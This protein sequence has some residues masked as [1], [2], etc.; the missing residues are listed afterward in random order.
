MQIFASYEKYAQYLKYLTL[1]L[2]AYILSGLS[3]KF[4]WANIVQFAVTPVLHFSKDQI[5]LVCA[6]LG[7]TISPYLFFWQTSQEVE[8]WHLGKK[9]FQKLPEV[10][11]TRE[12]KKMRVDVWSGMFISNLVMFFIIATTAS[13]LYAN[14]V[15]NIETASQA[16][17]ALAPFAGNNAYLLFTIGIIGTGFIAIPILAGS[18][19]YALSES[20]GWKFGLY[21]KLKRASAFYGAIIISMFI[22]L[23]MNFIGIDPIKALI[24]SAV[25]NGLIAPII[26]VQIVLMSSNKKIM[27]SVINHPLNTFLGWV[28]VFIMIGAGLLTL[29][30][31]I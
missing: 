13:T 3:L 4:D 5:V 22:G 8:E 26:L 6:V 15:V 19:S 25:L 31:L 20:F 28:I 16:A 17:S 30:A 18:A 29:V 14:G 24:Y 11:K 10:S 27:G 1:I 23:A 12:I 9:F 7:T 21:R 2:G